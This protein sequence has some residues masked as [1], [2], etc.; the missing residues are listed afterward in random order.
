MFT[1]WKD[2]LTNENIT[3]FVRKLRLPA[4]IGFFVG[5]FS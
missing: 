5:A 1:I 2:I 3:M 4:N